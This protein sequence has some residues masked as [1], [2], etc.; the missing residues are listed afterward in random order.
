[1]PNHPTTARRRLRTLLQWCVFFL[2]AAVLV[3]TWFIDGLAVPCRVVGGSMAGALLGVHREVVCGDCGYTFCC[4]TDVPP[5]AHAV[6]PN[7]GYAANDLGRLPDLTGDRVLIDRTAFASRAPRR[8]EV[9]AFRSPSQADQIAVKRVVGLPGESIEIRHGDV[10]ING[11]IQRKNLAQQHALAVLVNDANFQPTQEPTPP[12]RWR[13]E[14]LPS[15]FGRGAGG[16]GRAGNDSGHSIQPPPL[17]STR[18]HPNFLPKGEGTTNFHLGTRSTHEPL[19]WLVYHHWQ[20]LASVGGDAVRESPV[21]DLC[22]YNPSQP[23]REEDVHAVADLMLSFRLS[24]VSGQGNLLIRMADGSYCFQTQL[25]FDDLG[26]LVRYNAARLQAVVGQAVTSCAARQQDLGGSEI[27]ASR[28]ERLIEVSLID[29]QFL[30]AIDGRTVMIWPYDRPEPPGS[31]PACP[32]AIAAEAV[33]ATIHDL[34]VFRDVYYTHPI[35]P[36]TYGQDNRTTR[37]SEREYYMLGDNSPISEDS[38]TWPEHGAIDAKLLI[39][40]PLVA[41]PSVCLAL[42]GRWHFQVPN[43]LK[44]RYIR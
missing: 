20:R 30:L 3:K 14:E 37:L 24:E 42:R 9:A 16:Q 8:W 17:H 28:G 33:E 29:Q 26:R 4:G 2:L 18:P 1:M 43:P 23:R 22:G 19:E 25:Q 41:I 40:K 13:I 44:I 7:C 5:P 10:Y 12:S 36:R 6:C 31:P 27:P 32:L 38:R 35:G 15:P 21:A 11:R 34:Q 39:G